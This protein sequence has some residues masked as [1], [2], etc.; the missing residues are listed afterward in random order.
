MK[1]AFTTATISYLPKAF[2]LAETFL[3]FNR[4]YHFFIFII[5]PLDDRSNPFTHDQIKYISIDQLEIEGFSELINQSL[6]SLSV[7][8]KL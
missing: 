4:N 2:T 8:S 5:D 7:L 6:Y 1:C 3:K